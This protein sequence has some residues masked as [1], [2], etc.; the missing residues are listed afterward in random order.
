MMNKRA[1]NVSPMNLV[2]GFMLLAFVFGLYLYFFT[3]TFGQQ[4]TDIKQTA[5][6]STGDDDRDFVPDLLDKCPCE[7]G[8]QQ[9]SGCTSDNPT[10]EDK[11]RTCL[12]S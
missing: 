6:E 9:Y 3:N 2:V 5:K 4:A 10:D 12:D 7:E 1:Q 8:S 11:R